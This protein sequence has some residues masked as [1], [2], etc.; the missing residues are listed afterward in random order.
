MIEC[1]NQECESHV[2]DEVHAEYRRLGGTAL[3]PD[4]A[5]FN[6]TCTVDGS[7]ELTENLKTIRPEDFECA[8]CFSKAVERK[9][10]A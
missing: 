9:E 7:R 10:E 1:S 5:V 2:A 6:I 8:F 4:G 3:E